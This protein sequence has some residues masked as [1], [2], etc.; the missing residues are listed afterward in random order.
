MNCTS[1]YHYICDS[2]DENIRSP[3]C[4]TIRRHLEHCPNCR[5]YLDS[6]KKTIALYKRWPAPKVPL[7]THRQLMRTISLELRRTEKSGRR[8][9]LSR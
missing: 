1:A 7:H 5:A 6:V 9:R 2:L 4:R 8:R 3:R